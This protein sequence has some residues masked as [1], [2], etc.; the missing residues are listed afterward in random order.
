MSRNTQGRIHQFKLVLL[1]KSLP[2]RIHWPLN[3]LAIITTDLPICSYCLFASLFIH[4]LYR[5]ICCREVKV[6]HG[7][8]EREVV[9]AMW[10]SNGD[11]GDG[12]MECQDLWVVSF[13]HTHCFLSISLVMRF[14]KDHF[15]EYRE[16][17]IGGKATIPK[18]TNMIRLWWKVDWLVRLFLSLAA[19]L[20]QTIT[21]DDNTVVKFEIW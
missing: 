1:G 19:F 13:N 10:N 8:E 20:A 14:V 6:C 18:G 9:L 15:D 12:R 4:L 2:S 3:I 16:S 21:L 17:T 11:N 7:W 5:W